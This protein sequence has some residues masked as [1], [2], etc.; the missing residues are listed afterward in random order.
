MRLPG[1]TQ[2]Q[3]GIGRDMIE[4]LQ[5]AADM[6]GVAM[7]IFEPTVCPQ[8]PEPMESQEVW[9][10]IGIVAKACRQY[11][12]IVALAEIGLGD[13][14]DSNC[15]MLAETML[16]GEFLMRPSLELKRGSKPFPD[17]ADYRPALAL[18]TKLYLAHAAASKLKTFREMAKHV[19]I[20]SEEADRTV[21][22][23]EEDAKKEANE[24]G[25]KWAAVQK[26]NRTYSGL[27]AL[28]LAESIGMPVIYHSFYR[29]ASAGV[30][31]TDA[32]DLVNVSERPDGGLTFAAVVSDK[33]VAAALSFSSLLM[34][35]V[36]NTGNQRFGLGL[37][38][39]LGELAPRV[40]ELALKRLKSQSAK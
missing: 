11:R 13:V 16:A 39:R 3:T 25:P 27:T 32:T 15:R 12:G 23:A 19:D 30:H 18:R 29:P 9:V 34:L 31:A 2:L 17:A 33:G 40:R 6:L 26:E 24:I 1:E 5:L 35:Q 4:E 7:G 10:C 20:D 22:L 38:G 36:L 14:A 37:D 28:E 21:K 8:P